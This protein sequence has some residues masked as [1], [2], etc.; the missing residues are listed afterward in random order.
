MFGREMTSLSRAI[1]DRRGG[2]LGEGA[3]HNRDIHEFRPDEVSLLDSDVADSTRKAAFRMGIPAGMPRVNPA[4][5][6]LNSYPLN[7]IL[8]IIQDVG[9]FAYEKTSLR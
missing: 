3:R 8:G 5:V 1:R 6:K 4:A 9:R 7:H 2:S